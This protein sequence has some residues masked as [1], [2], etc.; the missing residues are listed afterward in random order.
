MG[1]TL[2]DFERIKVNKACTNSMGNMNTIIAMHLFTFKEQIKKSSRN[3]N[4]NQAIMQTQKTSK[5][6]CFAMT[7]LTR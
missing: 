2:A 7:V 4:L 5:H 3:S 1:D 6:P